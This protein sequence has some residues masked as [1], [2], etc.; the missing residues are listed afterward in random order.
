MAENLKLRWQRQRAEM[1]RPIDETYWT[2]E[3]KEMVAMASPKRNNDGAYGYIEKVHILAASNVLRRPIIVIITIASKSL[4]S[5]DGEVLSPI[6]LE[7]YTC[8]W[9]FRRQ[10]ASKLRW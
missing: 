1:L 7:G 5:T 4:A 3:W 2:T 8:L 10:D 9:T 6:N